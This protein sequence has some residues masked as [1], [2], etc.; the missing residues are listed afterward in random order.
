MLFI[1]PAVPSRKSAFYRRGPEQPSITG[2]GLFGSARPAEA[3]LQ[4]QLTFPPPSAPTLMSCEV[5][6]LNAQRSLAQAGAP[7]LRQQT[8]KENLH[9]PLSLHMLGPA[10]RR[11]CQAELNAT[12]ITFTEPRAMMDT[13]ARDARS[14][15]LLDGLRG[16]VAMEMERE[17]RPTN[18]SMFLKTHHGE[19]QRPLVPVT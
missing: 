13:K 12:Q 1:R 18:I 9:P 17:D 7:R 6:F 14:G 11:G 4:A 8:P 19:R 5:S 15:L 3:R 10:P 16:P 2:G